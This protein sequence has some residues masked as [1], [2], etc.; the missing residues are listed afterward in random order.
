MGLQI[1]E[2]TKENE[3][4]YLDKV[5]QLEQDVLTDMERH[6][7]IGQLFVTGKEDISDYVHSEDNTVMI[8]V[9]DNDEVLSATY[10]TQGQKPFTYND[11]TK[12]FKVGEKYQAY[13]RRQY[14]EQEYKK[15]VL[16]SYE[17][18]LKA[19]AYAREKILDEFPQLQNMTEFIQSELQSK[20]Q[21]DEKSPLREKVN[22]YMAEYFIKKQETTGNTDSMKPYEQ[23]YW[24]TAEEIGRIYGREIHLEELKNKDV[25]EYEKMIQLQQEHQEILTKGKLKIYEEPTFDE[26]Q[27]Y[28][29]NTGNSIEIDTY[30]TAP[31][32]RHSG[33]ARIL[34]YEGIKKHIARFFEHPQNKEIFL[35][36]TLHRENL[37]S[38]YVSE[39][40][41]L[42]DSLFVKRRQGRDR[43]VHITRIKREDAKQ[44]LRDMEDKLNVLYGYN[45]QNKQL[46]TKR[47]QTILKEQLDYEKEEFKRLNRARH[48]PC[49]YTGNVKDIQ[50]KANKILKLKQRL[51]Q[52]ESEQDIEI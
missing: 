30:L 29:A 49:K 52:I 28:S 26:E 42:K 40:F 25:L 39:F 10:I 34:V 47:K 24:M 21:F 1:L 17:E 18:K 35:C 31:N 20:N 5:A 37:S 48:Y 7:K 19:Y 14:T 36:S 4:K 8:S 43:E 3:E 9:D 2:L 11:I 23:F 51:K 16:E 13:V 38:K 12:Y 32:K 45:P 44:Y 41:G 46:S 6:G 27:Y 33:T 50:S 15:V 22:A